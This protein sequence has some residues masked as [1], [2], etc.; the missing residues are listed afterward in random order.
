MDLY[1]IYPG[2]AD[3][4]VQTTTMCPEME[5]V[6]LGQMWCLFVA[7]VKRRTHNL[8]CPK[9]EAQ[10]HSLTV[11]PTKHSFRFLSSLRVTKIL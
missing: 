7:K 9:K 8:L 1:R 2:I 11:F 4:D 10:I 6:I 3:I 5:Q